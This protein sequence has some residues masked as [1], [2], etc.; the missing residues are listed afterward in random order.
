MLNLTKEGYQKAVAQIN[1]RRNLLSNVQEG[2]GIDVDDMKDGVDEIFDYVKEMIKD[3]IDRQV[4]AL[5]EL[6]DKYGEIIDKKKES[7]QLTKDEADYQDEVADKVKEMAKLQEKINAL[8]LDDSRESIAK[9]K[10]LEEQLADL[11]KELASDQA[12]HAYDK[13]TDNLDK[14]QEAYEKEKDAEIKKLQE[15]I[16]SAERLDAAA[17]KYI[18]ENWNNLYTTLETWNEKYGSHLTKELQ[19]SWSK[20]LDAAKQY[21]D[22]LTALDAI[23]SSGAN[24]NKTGT[25]SNVVGT[26]QQLSDSD[27]QDISSIVERMKARSD[28]W[29]PNM[30]K[31]ERDALNKANNDDAQTI[32]TKYKLGFYYNGHTGVWRDKDGN[33]IYDKWLKVYHTGGVVGDASTLRQDEMM[34]ILQKG[35]IVLDKPKQQSLDS[36][37]KV[38]SAITS[39]LSASALP[40]LSKAAQMPVSGVNREVVTIP[41]ENVTNVTFGDTII[42]GADGDTVKQHEAVSRRMVNDIIEV[43]KIKK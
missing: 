25:D 19:A 10:D 39:G 41:R 43:L 23:G 22:Y 7:L 21:G 33:N 9:R 24:A 29:S 3:N 27:K 26:S 35:E 1:M 8:S 38:M 31:T 37:L 17:R 12:D 14:M 16:Q 11:Q 20:A 30:T 40:D 4:D 36:I 2:V 15:S 32:N 28:S 5:E 34:A 18:K 42:K 13:Q 6:K